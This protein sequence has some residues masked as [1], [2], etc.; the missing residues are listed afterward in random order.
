[1]GLQALSERERRD[2]LRL[3]RSE[4]IGPVTFHQLIRRFGSASEALDRIPDLANDRKSLK[5][6]PVEQAEA[7]LEAAERLGV[8]LIAS[9][10][11]GYPRALKAISD[12][13]P[14]LCVAGDPALFQRNAIAIVGA[15]NASAVGRRMAGDLARDL[16]MAGLVVVSGLARGIDGAAHAAALSSG[17]IAAVAGGIDVLYPPEHRDL[18]EEIARRGAVVS[19]RPIGFKPTGKDFPRRNRIISGLSLGVIVVEAAVKSGTLITA[20][21]AAEQGR[22]VFSVPGSP[23]DPRCQG[24]NR[25]IRDGAMLIENAQDVIDSLNEATNSLREPAGDLFDDVDAVEMDAG[26]L[27]SARREI[28][29]LLS[30]TPVHRD[31]LLR[32]ASGPPAIIADALLDLVLSGEAEEHTGG[33]FSLSC[34]GA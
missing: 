28:I 5:L 27:A 20:R 10:E 1:M 16:G 2:W 34:D 6:C 13:P 22:D 25:L 23:L 30:Y 19:E 14:V 12:A 33:R 7:E 4:Q 21:Y 17:T 8:S 32:E 11:P 24:T 29:G 15:R 9:C 3:I 18:T 31:I 26:A